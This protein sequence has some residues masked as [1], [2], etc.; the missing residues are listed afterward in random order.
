[1]TRPGLSTKSPQHRRPSRH[2]GASLVIPGIIVGLVATP[3]ATASAAP[4]PQS[5]TGTTVASD[6]FDR[7]SPS[8][9]GSATSGGGY[10]LSAAGSFEVADGAGAINIAATGTSRSARLS[11]LTSRDTTARVTL[12]APALPESGNG[13]YT[14]VQLRAKDGSYYQSSVRFSPSGVVT[15]AQSRVN[16]RTTNQT[17][18]NRDTVIARDIS[19]GDEI[20]L[21]TSAAGTDDVVLRSR[22]W[23]GDD[24]PRDWSAVATD[25]SDSRLSDAGTVGLWAYLSSASPAGSVTQAR[26]DDLTVTSADNSDS[27][28]EDTETASPT[29]QPSE[30]ATTDDGSTGSGEG[31]VPDTNDETPADSTE[32]GTDGG[33]GG[34]GAQVVDDSTDDAPPTGKGGE[35]GANAGSA[36]IGEAYYRAPADAIW[37]KAGSTS[38]SGSSASP[39]GSISA[40]VSQASSGQTIVVRGGT[41]RETVEIPGSKKV[42]IQSAPG[43]KVWL[44]GSR[45]ISNWTKS[46]ST[47]VSSGWS[48]T[49]DSSPTFTKGA[50]D[51]N[52]EHTGFLEKDYPLAAHPEQIWVNGKSLRQVGSAAAVTEGTFFADTKGKRLVIGTNPSDKTVLA[53]ERQKA[54]AIKGKGSTVRGIGVTRYANSVWQMGA[55]TLEGNDVSIENVQISDNATIGLY[56]WGDNVSVKNVTSTRNG[57]MGMGANGAHNISIVDS[58]FTGNNTERFTRKPVSGGL[59]I[60]RTTGV[61]LDGNNLSDNITNGLWLDESVHKATVTSNR[62]ANNGS[63]GMILE[64]S[65]DI[66]VAGNVITGSGRYGLWVGSSGNVNVWNNSIGGSSLA[67]VQ[68]TDDSRLNTQAKADRIGQSAKEVPWVLQNITV[69]NNVV[70]GAGGSCLLCVDDLT[71]KRTAGQ[72]DFTINSNVYHRFDSSSPASSVRWTQGANKAQTF[73]TI[74]Q[75][76]SSTG[77]DRQSFLAEGSAVLSSDASLATAGAN[78]ANRVTLSKLDSTVASLL[79]VPAG[80]QHAGAW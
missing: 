6:N 39:L 30:T 42:T 63:T 78:A 61:T 48:H 29:P 2:I 59:K 56:A 24:K 47:W 3:T 76:A 64:I 41:Y 5:D 22:A 72:M 31:S 62:L 34:G 71:K 52:N 74:S 11:E 49:F 44:D 66:T 17:K 33:T 13:V 10:R 27:P 32:G 38:G 45:Q 43:E 60:T 15:L 58:S 14:G 55:V 21:E 4:E 68:F 50:A 75:F 70:S 35:A 16:D 9:W 8:S 80:T 57:M 54:L 51:N 69:K 19:A 40:A 18:L 28:S 20:H 65:E 36:P 79:D 77:N 26:F 7:E 37:V 67:A 73:A 12:V 1:M 53:S 46:G 23:T 25:S